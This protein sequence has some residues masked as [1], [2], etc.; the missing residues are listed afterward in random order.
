MATHRKP[1]I[2]FVFADQLRGC[3][4]GYAGQEPVLTPHLEIPQAYVASSHIRLRLIM[5]I[6]V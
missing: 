6:G 4:V 5:P 3:S 1:N 2:I